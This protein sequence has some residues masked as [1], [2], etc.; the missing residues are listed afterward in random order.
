MIVHKAR[1]RP[2]RSAAMSTQDGQRSLELGERS[3]S[4]QREAAR[5]RERAEKLVAKANGSA[6]KSQHTRSSLNGIEF[7]ERNCRC[8]AAAHGVFSCAVDCD[9]TTDRINQEVEEMLR[10]VDHLSD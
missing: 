3:A 6:K 7:P 9:Q 8:L 5:I 2:V 10:L 1:P 4:L